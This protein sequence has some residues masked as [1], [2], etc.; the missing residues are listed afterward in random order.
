MFGLV[1]F[2]DGGQ[3]LLGGYSEIR[4]ITDDIEEMVL[5][6]DDEIISFLEGIYDSDDVD[7]NLVGYSVLVVAGFNY[8]IIFTPIIDA[9]QLDVSY[10]I[11]IYEPIFSNLSL[12]TIELI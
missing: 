8:A 6:F 10:Q 2:N 12:T 11:I 1:R 9:Q 4:E 7:Y 3:S 5:Q